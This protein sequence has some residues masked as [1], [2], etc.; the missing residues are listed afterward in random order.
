MIPI[1]KYRELSTAS[2]WM[3]VKRLPNLVIYFPDVKHK[4]FKINHLVGDFLIHLEKTPEKHCQRVHKGIE[5]N[6]SLR[7]R[8]S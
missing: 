1:P 7:I 4:S 8:K 3:F 6:R 2:I 5:A